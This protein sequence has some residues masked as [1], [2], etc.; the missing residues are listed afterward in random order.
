MSNVIIICLFFVHFHLYTNS[1]NKAQS[2]KLLSLLAQSRLIVVCYSNTLKISS[3]KKSKLNFRPS[4]FFRIIFFLKRTKR[5][6]WFSFGKKASIESSIERIRTNK[7]KHCDQ[8]RD[9]GKENVRIFVIKKI[10]FYIFFIIF[11]YIFFII[12]VG[13]I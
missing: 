7:K 1:G 8:E 11:F 13:L 4:F 10:F 12:F 3:C 2:Q 6:C 9:R 5:K